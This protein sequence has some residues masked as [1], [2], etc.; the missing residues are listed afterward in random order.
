M[1]S[2]ALIETNI[3][4]RADD[5]KGR[6]L[7]TSTFDEDSHPNASV[8]PRSDNTLTALAQQGKLVLDYL[9]A[10]DAQITA[11]LI[12]KGLLQNGQRLASGFTDFSAFRRNGWDGVAKTALLAQSF[13][14][15]MPFLDMLRSLRISDQASPIGK[16]EYM[17]YEHTLP[18]Q[19]GGH[20]MLLSTSASTL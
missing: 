8:S 4:R 15:F 12:R 7:E 6:D 19:Q 1:P 17:E 2:P 20:V 13:S 14:E 3:I 10:S 16:N 18:W 5:P 9:Q 11:D